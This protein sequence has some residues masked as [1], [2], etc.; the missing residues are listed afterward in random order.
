[1]KVIE[2]L[3]PVQATV[4]LR[5]IRVATRRMSLSQ[6]IF[7]AEGV[8][9]EGEKMMSGYT[10]LLRKVECGTSPLELSDLEVTITAQAVMDSMSQI[11]S[12]FDHYESEGFTDEFDA[13][14]AVHQ[15]IL[16]TLNS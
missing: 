3:P 4:L 16:N 2:C 9:A 15:S 13:E 6:P 14:I 7:M 10:H 11:A 1:M 5:S 8:Q 12:Q